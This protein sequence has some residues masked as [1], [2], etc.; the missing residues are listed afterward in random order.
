MAKEIKV[1][2]EYLLSFIKLNFTR[3]HIY[4][5]QVIIYYLF[6]VL[7]ILIYFWKN[8]ESGKKSSVNS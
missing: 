4:T 3:N 8:K 2:Q 7:F 1:S 5:D 6:I